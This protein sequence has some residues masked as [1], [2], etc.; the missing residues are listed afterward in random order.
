MGVFQ[1]SDLKKISGGEKRRYRGKRKFELGRPMTE[2]T[3]S[4][5]EL[6]VKQRTMGGNFK[7]KLRYAVVANVYDPASKKSEK[8]KILQVIETPSNRE[9]ARR[10]II[11]KGAKIKTEKGTAIVTS[12]PGQDGVINAILVS[13]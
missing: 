6:R 9:Y 12:R 7:L 10:G 2:T 5:Q 4:G 8:S 13:E 1:G 11:V 3:L